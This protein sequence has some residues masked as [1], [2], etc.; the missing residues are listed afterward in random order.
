MEEPGGGL[1]VGNVAERGQL[2]GQPILEHVEAEAAAI[3]E[4][5]LVPQ[6]LPQLGAAD[7]RRRGVFHQIVER[8]RSA[9]AEPGGDILDRDADILARAGFGARPLMKLEHLIA[10]W[11]LLW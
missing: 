2:L 10:R 3:V 11:T 8:H 6:P 9:A 5:G 1:E 4:P 7:L